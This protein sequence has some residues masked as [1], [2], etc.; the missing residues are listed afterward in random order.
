MVKGKGTF[1]NTV[2]CYLGYGSLGKFHLSGPSRAILL[3]GYECMLIMSHFVLISFV[4][5]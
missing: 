2:G 4:G 3:S 5:C 1:I